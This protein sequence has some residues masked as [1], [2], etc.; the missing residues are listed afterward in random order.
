GAVVDA[1]RVTRERSEFWGALAQDEGRPWHCD[2]P[3]EALLVP[4]DEERLAV[5]LDALLGNVLTHTAPP[6]GCHISVARD[7][8][9]VHIRIDDDGPGFDAAAT[10]RG[11]SGGGSTGLGLDIARR[12][13]EAAGG[14]LR[15]GG[16]RHG[17]RVD[18][19]LP[20]AG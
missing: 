16:R 6:A 7:G 18:L 19:R 11:R 1:A 15:I 3:D 12:T 9:E 14:S 10:T 2:A 20:S 8:G 17:G 4:L 13:A 5:V